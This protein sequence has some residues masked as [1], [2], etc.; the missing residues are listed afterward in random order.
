MSG[1]GL[2]YQLPENNTASTLDS[3]ARA[4]AT[5]PAN[6]GIGMV[7]APAVQPPA[8]PAPDMAP[9]VAP[10]MAAAQPQPKQAPLIDFHTNPLGAIGLVLSNVAAGMQGAELPSDKLRAQ[11]MAQQAQQ[12]RTAAL[13]LDVI[14]K[15]STFVSKLPA[16]QRGDAIKD[17]D[18]RF[19]PA[20]G[21]QS[22]APFL[23]A[24]TAG[25]DTQRDATLQAIKELNPSP[26]MLAYFG[27]NPQAAIKF[28][29][30]YN[31]HKASAETPQEAAAKA[32][33]VTQAT[34][35]ANAD[36]PMT[37]AEKAANAVARENAATSA[38]SL[39]ET[40]RHNQVS[41][42]QGANK[43]L[44]QD[45][46][47]AAAYADRMHQAE[48]VLSKVGNVG[49]SAKGYFLQG[50]GSAGN[51]LQ[52]PAFQ[53]YDQAKR[54]FVNAVLRKESGAAISQEEFDNAN[55]QYF[56][57]P[58]DSDAVVRQKAR[59]RATA[60]QGMERAAGI[61][62]QAP[63]QVIQYDAQGNRL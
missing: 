49:R 39:K 62:Y 47:N 57:V 8:A 44:T 5:P 63:G 7:K 50:L 11:Q 33:A 37:P 34:N 20:L 60:I 58:G 4:V 10:A 32:S 53:E 42:T 21:G 23:T 61:S 38:A 48:D 35:A 25:T 6:P 54:S 16:A 2:A 1:I 15:T 52:A 36:K 22:I 40:Q 28:L 56:P 51:Y 46:S 14:D 30:D 3:A 31:Q 24:I 13:A 18:S 43:P 55:K 9:S 17:L 19:S 59:N 29:D 12:Y 27:A 26:A 41:E 45:Q